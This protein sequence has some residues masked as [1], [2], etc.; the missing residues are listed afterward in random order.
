MTP[1]GIDQVRWLRSGS[2]IPSTLTHIPPDPTLLV[3]EPGGRRSSELQPTAWGAR[4]FR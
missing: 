4:N 1:P 2:R 3:A